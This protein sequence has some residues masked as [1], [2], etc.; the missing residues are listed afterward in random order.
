M[1]YVNLV[2]RTIS[3]IPEYFQIFRDFVCKLD[4]GTYDYSTTGIGWTL[5]DE[6]HA[7]SGEYLGDGG[8][9]E[10][11]PVGI[12]AVDRLDWLPGES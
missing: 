5:V 6:Y 12:Q 8:V 7:L 2:N 3:G 4:G 9:H 11:S 10:H 1:A